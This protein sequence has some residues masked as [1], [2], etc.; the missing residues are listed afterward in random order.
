MLAE[1]PFNS[2]RD[3]QQALCIKAIWLTSAAHPN[4]GGRCQWRS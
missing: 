2:E 4:A 1:V 3:E